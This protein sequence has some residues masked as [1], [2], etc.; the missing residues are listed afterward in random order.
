M[1]TSASLLAVEIPSP[2]SGPPR[3]RISSAVETHQPNLRG[4]TV[5]AFDE[6]QYPGPCKRGNAGNCGYQPDA[7]LLRRAGTEARLVQVLAEANRG[8][9][10]HERRGDDRGEHRDDAVAP[11][12]PAECRGAF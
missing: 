5:D 1:D 7:Q 8:D 10:P 6:S 4:S 11:A 2:E 9:K 12:Q 3:E